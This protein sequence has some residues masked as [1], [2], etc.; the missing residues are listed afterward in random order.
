VQQARVE[1]RAEAEAAAEQRLAALDQAR[2]E[3]REATVRAALALGVRRV[4]AHPGRSAGAAGAGAHAS[5][6]A[7]QQATVPCCGRSCAPSHHALRQG[8]EQRTE[9]PPGVLTSF[10]GAAV[11]CRTPL[12]GE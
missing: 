5:Q 1:A 11:L 3:E 10:P 7:A 2:R 8:T 4:R 9:R 12:T 6:W